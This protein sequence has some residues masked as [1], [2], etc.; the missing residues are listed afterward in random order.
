MAQ[1]LLKNKKTILSTQGYR[2]TRD[3]YPEAQRIKNF[4]NSKIHQLLK[5]YGYEEYSGPFVEHLELYAAKSSEEIVKDQLYSFQDKGERKLAIRP[6]M[7][8]TLARMIASKQKELLKPIRWYSIP[9]C[10]RFERP[11]RGRLREFDQLNV[12]LFGGNALD[13]DV[14]IIMTAIDI[15]RSL[16]GQYSDFQVKIN[17]RGIINQ[18]LANIIKISQDN[19]SPILRLFDKKDKLSESDFNQQCQNLNLNDKQIKS[20]NTFLQ[21]SIDEVID[22]LG[23]YAQ[24][25]QDLKQRLDI[26]TTL[27]SSECIKFAPDIMRGFDYYTGMVFEVFDTHPDNH[28]ALFGGGRYD[29]LVGAFGG[30]ELPGVGYGVGDVSLTNFMEVHGLLPRLFKETHVCVLRFSQ[31]DRLMAL[32]LAKQLRARNLNVETPI[33]ESK[34]GKQIQ[35]AEK[36]GAKAVAFVGQEEMEKNVFSVKWLHSGQQETFTNNAEGY[37]NFKEKLMSFI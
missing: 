13:E 31:T 1:N 18:F 25:A 15:L 14:E 30:D 29:N 2:G 17:H 32:Q 28:R 7:T 16:G 3:F 21:A 35:N 12:D 4:V 24:S 10:M 26:L 19:I 5:S 34:F 37:S 22:L 33:T 8:P 27:T 23:P 20:I 6:E 9:T 11:Q 36:L